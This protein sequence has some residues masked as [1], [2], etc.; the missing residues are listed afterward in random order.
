V[1]SATDR[2]VLLEKCVRE[3]SLLA[4]EQYPEADIEVIFTR[5]EDEDAHIFVFLPEEACEVDI[6]RLGDALTR[7]SV[8]ILLETGL[9]ILTGVYEASQ[10]H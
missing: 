9:L 2:A 3:L 8:E 5:F 6:D 4:K 7:R 10:R 1:P